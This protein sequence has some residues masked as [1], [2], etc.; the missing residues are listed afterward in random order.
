M[1]GYELVKSGCVSG[2][3]LRLVPDVSAEECGR[4]CRA[5][6]RCEA[7]EYYRDQGGSSP[8]YRPRDCNLQTSDD[9]SSCRGAHWN[10]DLYIKIPADVGGYTHMPRKCV[11]GHNLHFAGQKSLE[12]CRAECDQMGFCVAFECGVAYGGPGSRQ[13]GECH[14][15]DH[16][17]NYDCDGSYYNTDLYLKRFS[18]DKLK[19]K[20][21]KCRKPARGTDDVFKALY[22]VAKK[23]YDAFTDPEQSIVGVVW[24]LQQM[25]AV[26]VS[27]IAYGFDPLTYDAL[28]AAAGWGSDEISSLIE[29]F[30]RHWGGEEDQLLLQVDGREAGLQSG[31]FFACLHEGAHCYIGPRLVLIVPRLPPPPPHLQKIGLAL[32]SRWS[33]I[34]YSHTCCSFLMDL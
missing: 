11:K 27:G 28:Y 17:D 23:L 22:L 16:T 1:P 14:L 3:N 10:L 13:P 18:T 6:W 32:V 2:H 30:D 15:Q 26:M 8:K 24:Q 25:T 7:F 21:I 5:D 12:D 34:E 31:M 29:I 4:L 20:K 33:S 9:P 19:L